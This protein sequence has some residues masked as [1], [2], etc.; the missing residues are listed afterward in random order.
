[1]TELKIEEV[2]VR[3]CVLCLRDNPPITREHVFAQWLVRQV[4]GARLVATYAPRG[5]TPSSAGPM[6]ISRVIADVCAE[7]NAGW[8]SGL[9]VS[10]RRTL[11][12]RPRPRAGTL[13]APDRITLSRWF[14]K[15]AVLLAHAHG[16]ALVSTADRPR[17]VAGMPNDIEVFL[18]RR[19]RPRQHLDFALDVKTDRDV[20]ALRVRSVA[21]L[22]DDLVGHVAARGTL[23]SRHG[24]QLWPL[25][26]HTLRWETL[27]VI[28]P[29]IVREDEIRPAK[30]RKN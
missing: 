29:L 3:R 17:L 14:T 6:R 2:G 4:H 23:A 10:F 12:A 9:E 24:T 19:R 22:V 13:Q 16:G 27:P 8:M 30:P 7:C 11:F 28:T 1:M 21:I 18:A 25:R 5:E 15:T 26:S 20:N